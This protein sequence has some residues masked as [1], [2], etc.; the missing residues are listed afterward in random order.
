MRIN[1][2]V[3]A[4]MSNN[5]LQKAQTNLSKSIQRLSSGYKINSSADDPAGCAISERMRVQIRGLDQA[6]NNTADGISVLNT[7]EGGLVEIQSMLTRMKE[8][9]VQAANDVNSDEERAA[10]QSELDNINKEIDRI[11]NDT[12]F[13]TQSLLDGNLTRRVYSNYTGV[14]Q[15]EC[16]D[17]FVAG[18]YGVTVTQD[19]T[20]A[21]AIGSDGI[22]MGEDELVTEAQQ[23]AI[24]LNGY[25]V[26]IQAGDDLNTVISKIVDA[27]DIIG[28]SAYVIENGATSDTAANGLQYAGYVPTTEYSGNQLVIM[29][30]EYGTDH[31][32]EIKCDNQELAD[33]LGMP[34]AYYDANDSTDEPWVVQGTDV[35]AEF[36]TTTDGETTSRVGFEDSAVLSTE[37]TQITIKDVNNKTFRFDVPANIAALGGGTTDVVQEVTDV[38][39]MSIHIGANQDQVILVDIPAVTSYTLGTDT[40][41][42]M[43]FQTASLTIEKIDKAVARANEVRSKIGAYQNRFDHTTNNLQ[44]SN[45]NITSAMSTMTDTDMAEEMTEYTSLNVLTQ[46]ATSILSQANER[47]ST[48]LQLL[49]G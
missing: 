31:E 14:Y 5:S 27:A 11:S 35:Q 34:D 9:A 22:A 2:N 37:G 48:A 10:I 29:T 28:G 38:G 33:L 16:T 20:Q 4:I 3:T 26:S 45:E 40:I 36:T 1:T 13:N 41:N 47:P 43:T 24:T 23:G 42:V 6:E 17:N 15:L 46:A 7:A 12:E 8:L 44:I 25:T 39:T 30:K 19:A 21:I 49:Q 18:E 32:I